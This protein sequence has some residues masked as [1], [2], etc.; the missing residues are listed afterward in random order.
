[1]TTR[2]TETSG[3]QLLDLSHELQPFVP[4]REAVTL[5]TLCI[6]RSSSADDDEYVLERLLYKNKN[7]QSSAT[8]YR[9]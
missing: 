9:N 2:D 7:Q 3:Q 5:K 6:I 4:S 8:Y 1:M